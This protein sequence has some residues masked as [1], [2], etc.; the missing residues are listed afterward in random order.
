MIQPSTDLPVA[1][2]G[3]GPVGLEAALALAEAG[4]PFVVYE[5]GRT[6]GAS[7]RSWGHVRLFSPWSLDVSPR[8]RRHLEA[9]G[10][11]VPDDDTCPTG[12]EL[13]DQLLAPVAALPEV[14]PHLRLKTRVV[15]VGRQGLLKHEEIATTAR[16]ERP[17]RLLLADETGRESVALASVVLDCT[18][19]Y[20]QP[21]TLGDGGIPAPGEA[22]AADRLTRHVPDVEAD[23]AAWAGSRILVVGAGY[24]AQTAVRSL[25]RLAQKIPDTVILWALRSDGPAPPIDDDPLPERSALA[26]DAG[27]LAG[28]VSPHV[29]MR[30]GVVVESLAPTDDGA[31]RVRLRHRDG[32]TEEVLADRV[33]SLTGYV[34]DHLLYRQL[35]VHECYATCGP[36]KL[37]AALLGAASG[38]CLTGGG[39]GADVLKNPEPGF[40]IL[41]AKSYGRNS[42]FLM[43]TG[44]EQVDDVMGLLG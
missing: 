6:A 23:A 34:G 15:A 18:G 2:L 4:T 20:G 36:I 11:T 17:F 40:F 39:H 44:W 12:D 19:T 21:N 33:V 1:I 42:T 8:M 38:D 9:A 14:K 41:G 43:R 16:G 5:A 13:V 31:V 32:E 35:Q 10:V 27:N 7:V 26:R 25:D 30:P 24:S 29:E 28:G 3:G 37:S 22:A